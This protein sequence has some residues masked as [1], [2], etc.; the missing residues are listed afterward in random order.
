MPNDAKLGLILGIGLV[1][2]IGMVFF[3]PDAPAAGSTPPTTSLNGT[4]QTPDYEAAPPKSA[5]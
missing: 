4:R 3:R 2:V 1:A 5:D